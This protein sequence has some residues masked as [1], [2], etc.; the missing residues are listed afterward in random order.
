M[1]PYMPLMQT[2]GALTRPG[3]GPFSI[4]TLKKL[5]ESI[6]IRCKITTYRLNP[7][8]NLRPVFTKLRGKPSYAGLQKPDE[9]IESNTIDIKPIT[10]VILSI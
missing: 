3:F 2:M 10:D 7:S 4:K 9:N 8:V 6:E 1:Y 5:P